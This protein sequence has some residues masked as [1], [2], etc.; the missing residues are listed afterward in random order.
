M[1]DF[2]FGTL[3]TEESRLALTRA[4]LGGVTHV[5]RRSPRDPLPGQ[6]VRLELTL[7]PT[8]THDQAWVYWTNDGSDPAG[9]GG[10]ATNGFVTPLKPSGV[11]W[12]TLLWGYIRQF[13]G[14]IPGQ[15]A[16]TVVRYRMAA[17]GGGREV[18]A[19]D[20]AYYA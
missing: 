15:A 9:A 19:D 13:A 12:N 4:R 3:S 6:A 16:G 10:Q 14:E 2:V 8:Q 11:E 5:Q 17:G 18:L 1:D 7:G 20:G